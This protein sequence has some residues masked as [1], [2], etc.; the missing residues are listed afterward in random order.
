MEL[1][2]LTAPLSRGALA[3]LRAGDRVS[4]SGMIYTARDAA[5]KKLT[6]LLQKGAELP[7]P[8]KGALI[9]YAGP[10]PAPPGRAI[11]SVGP[12]TSYRMDAYAPALLDAGLLGMMGKGDRGKEVAEAVKRNGA[13]YFCAIGGLGAL[14]A[15]RVKS[16]RVVAFEELGT[17]AVRELVV[18]DFPAYVALDSKGT[19]FYV[20]GRE[21]YLAFEKADT[22]VCK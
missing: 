11:G 8:L 1:I 16:A 5:H 20:S 22:E 3:A 2:K 9:Y 12:T 7:F 18:E 10:T 19:S 4:I 15:T 13:V 6:E 21:N 14:L 17:E